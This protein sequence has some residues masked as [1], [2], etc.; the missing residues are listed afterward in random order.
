MLWDT[1]TTSGWQDLIEIQIIMFADVGLPP[2]SDDRT[3]WRYAQAHHML[4]LTNNR[5]S[6]QVDSLEQTLR[7]ENTPTTLPVLTIGNMARIGERVY[8]EQCIERLVEIGVKLDNYRGTG[9]LFI[10]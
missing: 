3:V 5:S 1:L 8:Q 2:N 7:E 9:R 4:L 6:D 10:P